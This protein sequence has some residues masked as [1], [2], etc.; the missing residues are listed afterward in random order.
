MT[1]G[2]KQHASEHETTHLEQGPQH[3]NLCC[4][5]FYD[6]L[7]LQSHTRQHHAREAFKCDICGGLFGS[8]S[9]LERHMPVHTKKSRGGGNADRPRCTGER[10]AL[11]DANNNNASAARGGG[12]PRR[13]RAARARSH[14]TSRRAPRPPESHFDILSQCKIEI[15]EEP[16]DAI[17]T[18]PMCSMVLPS[19]EMYYTHFQQHYMFFQPSSF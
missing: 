3:C 1:F 18:C 13:P 17:Y 4:R 12:R 9:M 6:P 2:S 11:R 16:E 14:Q 15:E 7:E 8:E 19:K 5:P 10:V